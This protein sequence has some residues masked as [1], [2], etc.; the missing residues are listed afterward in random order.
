MMMN[1]EELT[2][3]EE[4]R[5]FVYPHGL[6]KE[7][8]AVLDAEMREIRFRLLRQM[9]AEDKIFSALIRLNILMNNFIKAEGYSPS[10]GFVSFLKEYLHITKRKQKDFAQEIGL[11]SSQLSRILNEKESPNLALMYRLE[12]HS[13]S[14]IKAKTW[15]KVFI[16]K[17]E[18]EVENNDKLRAQEAAK[19]TN[20]LQFKK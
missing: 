1:E 4:V 11:H 13:D 18:A 15:W 8:K 20:G 19:V 17:M 14:V 2:P 3:E 5:A 6:S 10:Q 7:E 12:K 16:K 9:T